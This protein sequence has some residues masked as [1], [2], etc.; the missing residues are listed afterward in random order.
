[1]LAHLGMPQ[2]E[3]R[4]AHPYLPQAVCQATGCRAHEVWE[5]LW[6]LVADGLVYLDPAGQAADNWEW[7]LSADGRRVVGGGPWEPRDSQGYLRRLDQRIPELDRLARRYLEE[8]LRAFNARCHL[9]SSVLLGVASE[10]VVLR[11]VDAFIR[12]GLPGAEKLRGLVDNP[13]STY[14]AKSL[15][16]GTGCCR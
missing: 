12:A 3:S 14:Y 15:S 5:A 2:A 1:M 4:F 8:A 9:A 6:S 11:V 16:S 10:Q 13:R 7:K